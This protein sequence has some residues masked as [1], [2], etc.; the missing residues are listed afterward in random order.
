M[1]TP[2]LT[3][4]LVVPINGTDLVAFYR[5]SNISRPLYIRYDTLVSIL[6]KA[7]SPSTSGL[8][9]Q[10]NGT[11]NPVQTLLNLVQGSGITITDDG[12]GNITFTATGGGSVTADNGLTETAGN[13]QLGGTLLQNTTIDATGSYTL[14]VTG[15][16]ASYLDVMQIINTG[17]GNALYVE[18]LKGYAIYG[19]N[20]LNWAANFETDQGVALLLR[21]KQSPLNN[22][23]QTLLQLSRSTNAGVGANGLG[24]SIDFE[25]ETTLGVVMQ[26]QARIIAAW[27][28]ATY[29]TRTASLLFYTTNNGVS[30]K[31]LI[32][33][34]AG[35]IKLEQYGT[36]AFSGTVAYSLGVDASGN[37][38][39]FTGGG[40]GTVTGV[41]AT[42]P[43]TSSG[44]TA[45]VISTSMATNKL[46]GRG[47][48]GTV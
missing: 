12:A 35:Q 30:S 15:A 24:S 20:S 14:L 6:S 33:N 18:A 23:V 19:Y 7:I 28:S 38:I 25:A 8:L 4:F 16:R 47:T 43:I 9:L 2:S 26:L 27:T 21:T 39:E 17:D 45:P 22:N 11:N 40:G 34:G 3:D 44:G 37:V 13:V 48:A 36:G 46:I 10:T 31:K 1:A 41:T 5:G 29:A 32:I 42:L